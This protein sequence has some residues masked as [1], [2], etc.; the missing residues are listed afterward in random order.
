MVFLRTNGK[1]VYF[2]HLL[3]VYGPNLT[4]RATFCV[5][6]LRLE[7][8]KRNQQRLAQ[9]GLLGLKPE[10]RKNRRATREQ[11]E[12]RQ[13]LSRLSKEKEVDYSGVL[14]IRMIAQEKPPREKTQNKVDGPEKSHHPRKEKK[15]KD[16]Y[17]YCDSYVEVEYS[18]SVINLT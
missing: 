9:L 1:L 18:C 14:D 6:R 16:R 11:V 8:I 5:R 7:R 4:C 15:T 10:K 17:V 3:I 12:K 13:S 2:I